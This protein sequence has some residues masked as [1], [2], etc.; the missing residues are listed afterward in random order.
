MSMLYAYTTQAQVRAAF[1]SEHPDLPRR[2]IRN[3]SGN[4]LMYPTDTRCAFVDFVD[5]LSR[6]HLIS[7]ALAHRVTLSGGR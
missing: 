5:Y 2:R 6:E 3:Y 4:G 7:H 1:W